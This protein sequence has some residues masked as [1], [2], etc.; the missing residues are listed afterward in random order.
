V[1]TKKQKP[2]EDVKII[3]VEVLENPLRIVVN[4]IKKRLANKEK[5]G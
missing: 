5:E 3:S 2:V 1:H 4:N